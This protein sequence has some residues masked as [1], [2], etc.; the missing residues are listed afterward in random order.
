M[1]APHAKCFSL[2]LKTTDFN[3]S[4]KKFVLSLLKITAFTKH[5]ASN[6]HMSFPEQKSEHF[7]LCPHVCYAPPVTDHV[8]LHSKYLCKNLRRASGGGGG[9]GANNMQ[10]LSWG[11]QTEKITKT[12]GSR[13]KDIRKLQ[14]IFLSCSPI[15]P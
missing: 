9:G 10:P 4:L 13:S 6:F 1:S 11:T 15:H 3:V 14:A 12:I 8:P 5:V 7:C 2:F